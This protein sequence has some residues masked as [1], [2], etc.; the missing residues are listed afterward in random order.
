M[1]YSL[2]PRERLLLTL[3]HEEPDRI[4]IDLGSTIVTG[5]HVLAYRDLRN[6]L[7]LLE[8]P[9]RVRDYQQMLAEVEK[10]IINYF[11][12]DVLDIGRS[13]DPSFDVSNKWIQWYWKEHDM[14]LEFPSN[15]EI[16][17]DKDFYILQEKYH[18]R[19]PARTYIMPKKGGYYFDI[20]ERL[21]KKSYPLENV[22]SI[23][24]V[25]KYDWDQWKVKDEYLERLKMKAE[26]LYKYT[27]Y[28]LVYYYAAS[29]H[30]WAQTHLVGWTKWLTLLKIRKSLA[31]AI[32]EHMMEVAR[33]NVKKY[34]DA[35]KDYIQVI[36]FGDDLGTEERPQISVKDFREFYKDRW[37]EL[38]SYVKKH[39]RMYIF[40]HSCGSIFPLIR[41]LI[42]IGVDIIN[43]VQISAKDMQPEKLKNE[44]GEQV[45]F[46][47]GGIDTQHVLP[48]A[49]PNE[50]VEHVKR[51]IKIFAPKGGYVFAAVHNIQPNTPSKN[52]LT[53]FETVYRY[54]NYPLRITN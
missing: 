7:K 1:D 8:K 44:Y 19:A 34:V 3:R 17:E 24:D 53:L 52:I 13:I 28:G 6:E 22:N 37:E 46:W 43:P 38:F 18:H 31:E 54:G 51:I 39:S 36:A 9:I 50:I 16:K 14:K 4:P 25:K 33:Y 30:E 48:I 41:E 15:V 32:L 29:L 35:L 49:K 27:D 21:R 45:T 5:I 11:H 10:E 47:G 40:F 42:D 12:I 23:D 26:F 20:L 2:T